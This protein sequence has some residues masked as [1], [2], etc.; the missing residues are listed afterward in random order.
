M[1]KVLVTILGCA[2]IA[3]LGGLAFIYS[4]IYDVSATTPDNAL[5]AWVVHKVSDTSV[6]ARLDANHPPAGL[7]NPAKITMGGQLFSQSCAVCHGAPGL[8]QTAIAKGLNPTPPDLFRADRKPDSSENFQFIKYGVKMTAMPGFQASYSDEQIWS[9]V[10]FLNGL[11]GISAP[12]Y[13]AKT[14]I[15]N[16]G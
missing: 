1:I 15:P 6:G 2:A 4:G 8:A 13:T 11:P 7:D 14:S 12:D 5:V 9:L 3:V 10:A 16:G